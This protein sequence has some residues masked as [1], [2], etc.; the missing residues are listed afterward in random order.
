M[1]EE[2][3]QDVA[4]IRRPREMLQAFVITN[5]RQ[6]VIVAAAA[7]KENFH[8]EDQR[9]A[10]V[11]SAAPTSTAPQV[12]AVN[13]CRQPGCKQQLGAKNTCG[14]CRQHRS[15]VKQAGG[16]GQLQVA[17][18]PQAV[19]AKK[20]NGASRDDRPR[21]SGSGAQPA[22]SSRSQL[23]AARIE[24]RLQVL[25]AAVPLDAVI[26]AIPLEDQAKLVS[27]WLAGTI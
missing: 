5:A 18:G 9:M 21:G 16:N 4:Q 26:A 7:K 12:L 3:E 17:R 19:P 20:P 13:V 24:E 10:I 1:P 6:R 2:R 11:T 23:G 14:F 27:A 15:H 25:L 22:E 8:E